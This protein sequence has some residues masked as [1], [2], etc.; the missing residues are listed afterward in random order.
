MDG[1]RSLPGRIQAQAVSGWTQEDIDRIHAERRHPIQTIQKVAQ[2]APSS[3]RKPTGATISGRTTCGRVD[4]ADTLLGQI[5]ALG[6]PIPVR[7]YVFHPVRRWKMD[8]AWVAL[9]VSCEVDGNEWAQTNGTKG[10]HGGAKGMQSDCEKL[11]EALLLGWK[12][13]RFTGSQVRSGYAVS[14]L[15]RALV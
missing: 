12:P 7:D 1:N 14:I 3:L 4:L 9:K 2:N 13:Y 11:N 10:R 15:E 8:L 6:M 5:K